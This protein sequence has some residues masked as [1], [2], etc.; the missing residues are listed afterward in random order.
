MSQA[1]ELAHLTMHL[2]QQQ[3]GDVR[4][5]FVGQVTSYD[6]TTHRV[7]L[8]L[9][10]LLVGGNPNQPVQTAWVALGSMSVGNGSG[11]QAAPHVGDQCLCGMVEKE[12]GDAIVPA[13][14]YDDQN[15]TPFPGMQQGE[16][17]YRNDSGSVLY[18]RAT[19][20]VDVTAAAKLSITVGNVTVVIDGT[21][22][23]IQVPTGGTV[24][25]NG[26]TDALALVSKLV[27]A[28]NAHTHPD[29]Q[30]GDT[31]TPTAQ[32]DSTTVESA[33]VKVGG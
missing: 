18:F 30:G 16:W 28:F 26:D 10:A 2:A 20:E 24:S 8:T 33:L 29:P 32:W 5:Q 6:P 7:R 17:G 11:H 14:I 13:C 22:V 19:G 3:I 21:N 15:A 31:G 27:A 1:D 23:D 25:V 9:P 4:A 12:T